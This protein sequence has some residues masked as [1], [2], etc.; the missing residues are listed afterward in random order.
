MFTG[1]LLHS[2]TS[3][4]RTIFV[5]MWHEV[6]D[7]WYLTHRIFARVGLSHTY[8]GSTQKETKQDIIG[9]TVIREVDEV[10][11][12][13]VSEDFNSLFVLNICN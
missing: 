8:R 9:H 3:L 7:Y 13:L 11:V 10:L 2:P 4:L 12:R 1:Y 6:E 5:R